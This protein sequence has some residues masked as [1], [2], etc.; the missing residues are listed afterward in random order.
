MRN[1]AARSDGRRG[2]GAAG[3]RLA[4][5]QLER[6][7]YR[8][9]EANARSCFGE[10]DLV[11]IDQTCLVGVEV[12]TRRGGLFGTPEES[13]TPAKAQRLVRLIEAYAHD[14]PD[15]PRDLRIDVVA[16]EMDRQGRLLRI[17]II[18]DAVSG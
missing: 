7:G 17:E 2:L 8:I 14:H 16:V 9:I 11:A 1:P 18:K 15:L 6:Q 10:L 4:R 3:E 12:R 5:A 13:I